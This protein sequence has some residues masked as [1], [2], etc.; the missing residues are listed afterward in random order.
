MLIA[1]NYTTMCRRLPVHG[2]L[3]ARN[4]WLCKSACT[5]MTRTACVLTSP[6]GYWP[7]KIIY[8][9]FFP[10]LSGSNIDLKIAQSSASFLPMLL[11]EVTMTFFG[12]YTHR[13]HDQIA[14]ENARISQFENG[15]R[16]LYVGYYILCPSQ[17][18]IKFRNSVHS[19]R[20]VSTVVSSYKKI[21]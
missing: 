3:F 13:L 15:A 9:V 17:H 1:S 19:H 21:A 7:L 5:S 6:A 2:H 20:V 4:N 11:L 12:M 10:Q 8:T 14:T 18:A 16:R